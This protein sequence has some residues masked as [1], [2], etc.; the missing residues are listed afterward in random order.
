M[1]LSLFVKET[2]R[3]PLH[4]WQQARYN[5]Q[6]LACSAQ[7]H[8]VQ[9]SALGTRLA[10]HLTRYASQFFIESLEPRLLLSVTPMEAVAPQEVAVVESAI[11]VVLEPG[12]LPNLDIDLNGTLDALTDGVVLLRHL[13]GFTGNTITNGVVDPAGRRTDPAQ[14]TDYLTSIHSALDIDLDG[15]VDALS[16]GILILR[17][18]FG[19]E[20]IDLIG[21]LVLNGQRTDPGAIASY[22]DTMN[23]ER[24]TAP[25]LLLMQL[26]QDTGASNADGITFNPTVTGFV[27][28]INAIQSFRAGFDA[29]PLSGYANV[30]GDLSN[31]GTFT[32]SRSRLAQVA[33]GVLA[34]GSHT[35]HVEASDVRGNVTARDVF[36]TLDTRA[37]RT[38]TFTVHPAFDTGLV[39]DQQTTLASITLLGITEIGSTVEL[40]VNG[41]TLIATPN[42]RFDVAG[43]VEFNGQPMGLGANTFT[44]TSTDLAGNTSS[45]TNTLIRVVSESFDVV[46]EWKAAHLR[47]IALAQTPPP[48]A[49]R[50][51]AIVQTAVFDAVNGIEQLYEPYRV[52]AQAPAG[53]SATAA[54]VSAAHRALSALYPLQH[55]TFDALLASSLAPVPNGQAK[56]D[57]IAWG[58]TVADEIVAWRSNDGSSTFVSYTPGTDPGE[59]QPTPNGFEPAL[60]PQWPDVIP[61]A[62]T[63][64]D[65][66]RPGGP[67]AL[68]SAAYASDLN[69]VQAY[70]KTI[71][72]VRSAEQTTIARF[73]ADGGRSFTPPGHWNQI[74][75]Q[76]TSQ[77]GRTLLDN[78]RLFALLD[79]ALADAGIVSWD[80]KYAFNLWRPITAIR[81]ADLDGNA[82]T[83]KDANWTSLLTTPPFPEYTSGHSTFSGAA[84]TVLDS[85]IGPSTGF[86]TMSLGLPGVY[87]SFTGF[88]QAANEAGQSRIYGGI[89]FQSA[90]QDGL[91]SGRSLGHY[92]LEQ[93]LLPSSQ[94]LTASGAPV[95]AM[96]QATDTSAIGV[97]LAYVQAKWIAG[98][99]QTA[100]GQNT[101][102][103]I[104]VMLEA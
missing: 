2:W 95:I 92:V 9:D 66:F 41:P 73:W 54:A 16:D 1:S 52:T 18:A 85:L 84:S 89:H 15:Q 3:K 51:L 24:E 49:A 35:L 28:D 10:A 101:D 96:E 75:A 77:P 72:A 7:A 36:F 14:I 20:G 90:N 104:V 25:P 43:R 98:F 4:R 17:Y 74:T 5:R 6:R 12:P 93:Q 97:S 94:V 57:G 83:T 11:V 13:L 70:G 33:G 30:L 62:M 46:T 44:M 78:A 40:G 32:L 79:M 34:D 68:G 26:E 87:R 102:D 86:S 47:A 23:P 91:A 60:L 53:A 50:N 76:F 99:L 39:G 37:P 67:P 103:D 55:A 29:A 81:Q 82:A 45:Y 65:Q 69:E 8:R 19:F 61:F 56:T 58:Q 31:A 38:P 48:Y 22:L 63:S 42:T 59:W 88:T 80:A 100:A 27:A 71:S 64:G 21:P